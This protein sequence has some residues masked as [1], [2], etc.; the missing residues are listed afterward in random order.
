MTTAALPPGG[1]F[2]RVLEIFQYC[3]LAHTLGHYTPCP[4]L[5]S[6]MGTVTLEQF[7]DYVKKAMKDRGSPIDAMPHTELIKT[8]ISVVTARVITKNGN[9][10][11]LMISSILN[12]NLG[13]NRAPLLDE[14]PTI[15]STRFTLR[16][17]PPKIWTT[18]KLIWRTTE[19]EI[20]PT[21]YSP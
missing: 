1:I 2:I 6:A 16:S 14:I 15:S 12:F 20:I 11:F 21:P 5:L 19:S 3:I 4:L 9:C 13:F 17:L 10:G 8:Y 18:K 7:E